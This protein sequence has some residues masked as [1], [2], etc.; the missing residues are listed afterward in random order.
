MLLDRRAWFTFIQLDMMRGSATRLC[1][2]IGRFAPRRTCQGNLCYASHSAAAAVRMPSR[3]WMSSNGSQQTTAE[4][5]HALYQQQMEEMQEERDAVFGF[6]TEDQSAWS[7]ASG[8]KHDS[9]FLEKVNELRMEEENGE[10]LQD[11]NLG[12]NE[13]TTDAIPSFDEIT[14]KSLTHLSQDG[15]D[16]RMVDVGTKAVTRRVAVAES[17]VVFPPEVLEAFTITDSDEMVGPK[18]P[19]FA[20]AKIAGIMA[21]K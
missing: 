4:E 1:G 15:K 7:N 2:K 16:V 8:H 10:S 12:L 11:D 20:T 17:K 19:I 6:T 14:N 18:G 9:S 13:E 5:L 21:A 3:R